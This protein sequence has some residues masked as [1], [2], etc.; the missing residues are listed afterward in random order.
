MHLPSGAQS[1]PA[2][3]Y[4]LLVNLLHLLAVLSRLLLAK[5]AAENRLKSLRY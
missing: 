4:L 5:R 1:A 2:F 3:S